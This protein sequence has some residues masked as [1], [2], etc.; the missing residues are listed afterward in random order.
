[1]RRRRFLESVGAATVVTLTAPLE[2]AVSALSPHVPAVKAHEYGRIGEPEIEALRS[3]AQW[4]KFMDLSVGGAAAAGS[5]Y[6][7][8]QWASYDSE[9]KPVALPSG[10]EDAS[11]SIQQ[12]AMLYVADAKAMLRAPCPDHLAD[13]F[14]TAYAWLL[15]SAGWL[16]FDTDRH[17]S[18]RLYWDAGLAAAQQAGNTEMQARIMG[19][20]SRQASWTGQ[21]KR[22]L[23]LATYAL[24]LPRL[25]HTARSRLHA[26][27][28]RAFGQMG[29]LTQVQIATDKSDEEFARRGEDDEMPPWTAG[30]G[31]GDQR[32]DTGRAYADLVLS[33]HAGGDYLEAIQRRYRVSAVRHDP[34]VRARSRMFTLANFGAVHMAAGDPEQAVTL[35]LLAV[36][37]EPFVASHRAHQELRILR[38]ACERHIKR[39]D[40]SQL[41]H[42]IDLVLPHGRFARG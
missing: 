28:A 38:H 12:L 8:S 16:K 31:E 30:F 36:D 2:S 14:M 19:D 39:P 41:R 32:G 35:G 24:T 6:A 1:M 42:Q 3:R 22:G 18:A 29:D 4:L 20:L 15:D 11:P 37:A 40:V 33:G 25:T 21:P 26:L 9:P 10:G 5:P 13:G 27:R 34:V 23:A 7:L 17:Q